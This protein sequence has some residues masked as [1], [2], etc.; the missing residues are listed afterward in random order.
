MSGNY[1]TFPIPNIN[2]PALPDVSPVTDASQF[3]M[4]RAGTGRVS[5]TA[6]RDYLASSLAVGIAAAVGGNTG[7]N[8]LHNSLFNVAQRGLGPWNVNGYTLDRWCAFANTDSIGVTRQSFSLGSV[9]TDEAAKYALTNA[10]IGN[11][12]A[13]ACNFVFQPIEDVTRLGNK[14]VTVSFWAAAA[15]GA[16][17]LG[18]SL[19]QNFGTGGSVSPQVQGIGQSV[20]LSTTYTRYS[21]TFTTVS[22]ITRG[23]GTNRDDNTALNFW[24]SSG[25]NNATRAGNIGVQSGTISLWGVQLEVGSVATPLEKPDPRYDLANCQRFFQAGGVQLLTYGAATSAFV[26]TLLGLPVTM[27]ASPTVVPTWTTQTN[28]TTP[29]ISVTTPGA[30][31][32]NAQAT[33]IGAVNLI[34]SFTASSDL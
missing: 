19:D 1:T 24:Y 27:R 11:A 12:G 13:A 10:F 21:L 20:T 22:L 26:S 17:K 23:L 6:L 8:L 2:I 34:G 29:T 33:G 25:A 4:E 7:R 9:P 15:S 16:P 30:L 5:A 14:T 31:L 18:V 3:I 28:V 32:P